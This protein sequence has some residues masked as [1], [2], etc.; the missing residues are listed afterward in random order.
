MLIDMIGLLRLRRLLLIRLWRQWPTLLHLESLMGGSWLRLDVEVVNIVVIDDIS[1]V[2]TRRIL[3]IVLWAEVLLVNMLLHL[4]VGGGCHEWR[5][6]DLSGAV[7]QVL[8]V[9]LGG[10]LVGRLLFTSLKKLT[11]SHLLCLILLQ[12]DV[13]GGRLGNYLSLWA[14]RCYSN[15]FLG[16]LRSRL[17]LRAELVQ[18]LTHDLSA[19]RQ[20]HTLTV[21]SHALNWLVSLRPQFPILYHRDHLTPLHLVRIGLHDLITLALGELLVG[22]ISLS[23]IAHFSRRFVTNRLLI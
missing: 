2:L 20:R 17:E 21:W 13:W 14:L 4:M 10:Q 5:V 3:C 8:S 22:I 15:S 11:G 12:L 16:N 6:I 1:D 7:G 9:D 19:C 23:S 18:V